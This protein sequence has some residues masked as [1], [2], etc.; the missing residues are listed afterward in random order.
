MPN[1]ILERIVAAKRAAVSA[2]RREV[3]LNRLRA[4]AE[5]RRDHR[6]FGAALR[7]PGDS[8]VNVI[9]EI[10]RASP[11]KGVI[12][13]DLDPAGLAA[14]YAAGGAAAVSVLTEERFFLGSPQDLQAARAAMPLP[15]LRKDFIVCAYQVLE[16]AAMGADAVLLIVRVLPAAELADLIALTSGLGL[17]ALVEV[18]SAADLE[19]AERAGA[20]LIGINNRD[21]Q[22]FDTDLGHTL[23]LLPL[24]R[25]DQVAVAASGIRNREDIRRYRDHGVFNFLIGESLV[26]AER[27]EAFLKMLRGENEEARG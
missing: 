24:L 25:P 16:S 19:T 26:L 11:S 2:A 10:K 5:A 22:S 1:D 13:A 4:A 7:T 17:A 8:G 12:R 20:R 3:P 18:Y 15:V 27:P 6:P 9:A 14:A 23:R 21:L